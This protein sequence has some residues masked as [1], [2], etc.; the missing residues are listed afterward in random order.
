MAIA[1]EAKPN[2]ATIPAKVN[3]TRKQKLEHREELKRL[4]AEHVP[5]VVKK[6]ADIVKDRKAPASAQIAAGAQ[7][8]DRFAG[9]PKLTDDK[10]TQE[11]QLDRISRAELLTLI[12]ES[13]AGLSMQSRATIAEALVA[14]S[15]GVT[16]DYS[17]IVDPDFS[18]SA[19]SH[20]PPKVL[21]PKK[22]KKM[23][24]R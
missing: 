12:C 23:P 11:G 4:A 17:A 19:P 8:L 2:G 6:L 20:L 14:A 18:K 24:R 7:L 10:A 15:S 13:L 21:K 9:K 3:L 16:L 5:T 22:T 1:K